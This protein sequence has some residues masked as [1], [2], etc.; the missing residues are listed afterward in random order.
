MISQ[1]ADLTLKRKGGKGGGGGEEIQAYHS[2]DG[3]RNF[4]FF[5][6]E[7]GGVFTIVSIIRLCFLW[8]RLS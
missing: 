1:N 4:V 7:G 3:S 6:G 2:R 8:I 5:G